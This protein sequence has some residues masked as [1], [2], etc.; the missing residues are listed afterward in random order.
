MLSDDAK[1]LLGI[2]LVTVTIFVGVAFAANQGAQ[3]PEPVAAEILVREDSWKQETPNA[4]ITLVEF[5]DLECEACRAAHPNIKQILED[6]QGQITYVIRYF[7]LHGNS[8]LAAKAAEAAGEQD[9]YWE[10]VDLLFEQQPAWGEKKEPQTDLFLSYAEELGLDM[11]KFSAVFN[12]S[13]YEDKIE[14]DRRDGV[15]AGVRGTPTI[16]LNGQVVDASPTYN[17]LKGLVDNL[18]AEQAQ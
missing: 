1:V 12:S 15:A 13:A 8:E 18:L 4:A 7:P 2:G 9:K 16:F 11:E 6:Y 10:M 3:P 5:L 17:T 14:R